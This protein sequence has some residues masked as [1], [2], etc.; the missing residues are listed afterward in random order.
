MCNSL[1][2]FDAIEMGYILSKRKSEKE[3]LEKVEAIAVK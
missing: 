2:E 3:K 1:D